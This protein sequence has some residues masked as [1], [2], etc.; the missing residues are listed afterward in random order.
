MRTLLV[1][2]AA[3]IAGTLTLY[4]FAPYRL[5]GLLPLS[6]AALAQLVERNPQLAF[7][8]GY[9]WGV[10]AYAS[11]FNWIYNSLHDIAGLPA[12]LAAPLV[13]LLP[14]YLAIWPGLA[15]WLTS[16]IDQR[17]WVR[18]LLAFRHC[19]NWVNGCAAG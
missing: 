5:Y 9:V 4:G 12:M 13:L 17:A 8:T 11:N 3:A 19:G 15:C 7:R 6:L 1:L 14:A 16:R 2:I 18:W 10:A